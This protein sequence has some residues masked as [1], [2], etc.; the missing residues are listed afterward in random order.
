MATSVTIALLADATGSV[1]SAAGAE[2]IELFRG[3][4]DEGRRDHIQALL[5]K[6]GYDIGTV[7]GVIGSRTRSAIA[8]FQSAAGLEADGRASTAVLQALRDR[9]PQENTQK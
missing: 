4:S 5:V 8:D 9:A 1:D 7:D 3:L 6:I 2:V